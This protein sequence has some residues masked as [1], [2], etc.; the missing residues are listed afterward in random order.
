MWQRGRG[1]GYKFSNLVPP[2]LASAG[3]QPQTEVLGGVGEG[4]GITCVLLRQNQQPGP[5]EKR[6]APTT[7]PLLLVPLAPSSQGLKLLPNPSKSP[8]RHPKPPA[9]SF[10]LSRCCVIGDMSLPMEK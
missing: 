1:Q 4:L 6:N 3:Q 7:F 8:T 5:R 10:G 9:I 2:P